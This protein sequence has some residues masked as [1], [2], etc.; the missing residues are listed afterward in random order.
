MF[1]TRLV[2][3]EAND[4]DAWDEEGWRLASIEM[5]QKRQPNRYWT[6]TRYLFLAGQLLRPENRK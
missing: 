1:D 3:P 5:D 4:S 6:M 2:A